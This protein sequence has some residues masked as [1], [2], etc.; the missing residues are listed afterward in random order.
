MSGAT[1]ATLTIKTVRQVFIATYGA[2][3]LKDR[4]KTV[5]HLSLHNEVLYWVL[6]RRIIR[7]SRM[8]GILPTMATGCPIMK[9]NFRTSVLCGLPV[10]LFLTLSFA[11]SLHARPN[12]APQSLADIVERV[13]PSVVTIYIYDVPGG[14]IRRQGTGWFLQRDQI[15]TSHHVIA[16]CGFA[17][18]HLYGGKVLS[19]D[20]VLATSV[21][22]DLVLLKVSV[23]TQKPKSLPLA[24]RLPRVGEE[25]FVVGTPRGLEFSVS[26]GIISGIRSSNIFGTSHPVIQITAAISQ[27][28]SG[29][30]VLNDAGEVV[31]VACASF[32]TGQSLNLAVSFSA[33]NSLVP[34]KMRSVDTL[35]TRQE[36]DYSQFY[37]QIADLYINQAAGQ[38]RKTPLL[39]VYNEN[40][41]IGGLEG[42]FRIF[43]FIDNESFI[44]D[45]VNEYGK[46]LYT[47]RVRG[48]DRGRHVDGDFVSFSDQT[49]F[50]CTGTFT[51]KTVGGGTRTIYD[52]IALDT[53]RLTSAIQSIKSEITG[54]LTALLRE[55]KRLDREYE[56]ALEREKIKKQ[57]KMYAPVADRPGI[58]NKID[59]LENRLKELQGEKVRNLDEYKRHRNRLN[60][61]IA[62]VRSELRK[63]RGK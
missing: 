59:N 8:T 40:S 43:Q 35:A 10:A 62:L 13:R 18:A 33:I 49:V 48:I 53:K 57:I 26:E 63:I 28:S 51:Y 15:V 55:S 54:R 50:F 60:K 41:L 31:G 12:A 2:M 20:G 61:A 19:I 27:G 52:V 44:A 36:T 45:R 32:T 29:S 4:R 37:S 34:G 42:N 46:A 3:P 25:V 9:T 38:K 14:Q 16:G 7:A 6:F 22:D 47:T 39:N 23:G 5:P 58:K 21:E 56:K 24:A 17:E 1:T 11:S 30:P